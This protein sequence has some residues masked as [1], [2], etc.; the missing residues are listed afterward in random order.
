MLMRS[1]IFHGVGSNPILRSTLLGVCLASWPVVR[2]R[3]G[4]YGYMS[5]IRFGAVG[6]CAM[7]F[8]LFRLRRLVGFIRCLVRV[9]GRLLV[10]VPRLLSK[11]CCVGSNRLI[12]R[13]V[14]VSYPYTRGMFT[15]YRFGSSLISLPNA[16]LF[17][18]AGF[19]VVYEASLLQIPLV[20]VFQPDVENRFFVHLVILGRVPV[21]V[22][23]VI[24]SIL[25]GKRGVKLF[26]SSLVVECGSE[27]A[28]VGVRFPSFTCF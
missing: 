26:E 20:G 14:I 21:S 5:V 12:G 2:W 24:F 11:T 9:R 3:R 7:P 16:V 15:N 17:L 25:F 1:V 8:F 13:P 28:I 6:F 4:V 19:R 23:Y 27:K 18:G 22:Y 10:C